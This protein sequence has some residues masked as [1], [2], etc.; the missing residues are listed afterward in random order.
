MSADGTACSLGMPQIHT[1]LAGNACATHTMRTQ[2]THTAVTC[3]VHVRSPRRY[4][5]HLRPMLWARYTAV[6]CALFA[7]ASA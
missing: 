3:V 2:A 7:A 6:A 4:C 5:G 1:P